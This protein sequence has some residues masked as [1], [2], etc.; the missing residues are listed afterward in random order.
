MACS[1]WWPDSWIWRNNSTP[2]GPHTLA[3]ARCS[4]GCWR[5]KRWCFPPVAAD[6][7]FAAI[8]ECYNRRS[9]DRVFDGLT[10]CLLGVASPS[11][12]IR[13]TRTSPF[14]IGTR[15]DLTDFSA[16]EAA[17]LAAGVTVH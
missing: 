4:G 5:W 14:N 12:L 1:T 10:F 7:F 15:I 6:G 3:S 9:H 16:E 17:P 2:S 11:D 13:D 8:R